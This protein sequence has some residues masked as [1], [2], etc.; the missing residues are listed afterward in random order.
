MYV[1]CGNACD[2]YGAIAFVA[3]VSSERKAIFRFIWQPRNK[4]A[5]RKR[6]N[7]SFFWGGGRDGAASGESIRLPPM[8]LGFDSR[9]RRLTWVGFVVG[10]R[11]CSEGFSPG[12]PAFLPPQKPKCRTPILE[13][14][15]MKLIL[16]CCGL[17]KWL[18]YVNEIP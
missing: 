8:W 7:T 14:E 4:R 13:R 12:T 5:Q 16:S 1:F 17:F 15:R 6:S 2:A 18:I 3:S 9:S 10:S 11:P